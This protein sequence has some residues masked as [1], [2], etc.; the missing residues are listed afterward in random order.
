MQT[1]KINNCDRP[2]LARGFCS[3][4]YERWH[5][6]GD[7]LGGAKFRKPRSPNIECQVEGCHKRHKT[8]G[9]CPMHYQRQR[10]GGT[11]D[12]DY[13]T[14][15]GIDCAKPAVNPHGF[16]RFHLLRF[17]RFG[18]PN[19]KIYC[20]EPNCERESPSGKRGWCLMHYTRWVRGHDMAA[21][22]TYFVPPGEAKTGYRWCSKCRIELPINH[23]SKD[24]RGIGGLANKCRDCSI[25]N[26]RMRYYGITAAKFREMLALQNNVCAI[27]KR[28]EVAHHQSGALRYL[29]VDHDHKCCP[30]KT[31]CGSC[32]RAL[33][34]ARCNSVLGQLNDDV[35]LLRAM[36]VYLERS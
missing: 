4:H 14:C 6:Y 23:F 12:L 16:C 36:L 2:H 28:E 34:C 15:R 11:L 29:S 18:D 3:A 35:E 26:S 20:K 1:C 31:S 13:G 8:M 27:C 19:H 32:V 10:V 17:K 9:L 22:P 25:S 24:K 7:P 33:L 5:K 21:P 30:S